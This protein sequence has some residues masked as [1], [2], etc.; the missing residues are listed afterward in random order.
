M[1][2]ASTAAPAPANPA[3]PASPLSMFEFW[4][5]WIFYTPIVLYWIA[6]GVRHLDFS[7]P[8][9]AN[10][11]IE[12]GGLCGESKTAIL[13][14]A[15]E[16]AGRWIAP[17]TTMTTTGSAEDA[18]AARQALA[19]A[20]LA[21]PI[22]LKPDIGCN[23]T[24]VKLAATPAE[25]ARAAAQF[26]PG[27]GLML[28]RLIPYE[29]EAG[30]FYI[31]HPDEPRGRITSLTY[32]EAPVIVGDGR[33]TVR[34]LIDADARTGLVPHLYLPRLG[35]RVHDVLPAGEPMRLVFAGNHCKGSIFRNG[36]SDITPALTEQIDRI[37]QD[38]PDFHFGRIDLKFES[39]ASLRLGR[40]FEI[41]EINGV[42]SEATH[43]W[44]SRTT[45]R[46]AYA[47]QFSH[48]RETFRIGAKKKKAGWRS[49]GALTMLRSWRRQR[50]L[51][52]SYPM[53]D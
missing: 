12:T 52:A 35:A 38:I 49:S 32:K 21:L 42:G 51:L 36:A 16:T 28:Q 29:H 5:G 41:I 8:T 43:I 39:I 7:L 47:A 53:N 14:M 22:V 2:H 34:Q 19:Q 40:G 6:M 45:L 13:D 26:P 9:A 25:L 11:R 48:Y 30:V 37:M 17:Y 44:D 33:S 24:G 15:G 31:R 10:P 50:K 23:G 46:E 20:G 1:N 27:T 4:P 3:Q 18:A